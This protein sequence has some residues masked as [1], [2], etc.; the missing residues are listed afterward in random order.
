ME[1]EDRRTQISS[2]VNIDG[3]DYCLDDSPA[4]QNAKMIDMK[5]N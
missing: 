4:D 1:I 3:M 5:E 2:V